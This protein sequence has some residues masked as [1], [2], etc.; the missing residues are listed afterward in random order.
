MCKH[1]W[2]G[3]YN[4]EPQA[5]LTRKLVQPWKTFLPSLLSSPSLLFSSPFPS[6]FLIYFLFLLPPQ[7]PLLPSFPSEP[8]G[9][10]WGERGICTWSTRGGSDGMVRLH[11][12]VGEGV[13]HPSLELFNFVNC[14]TSVL[15]FLQRLPTFGS[16]SPDKRFTP[17]L[18]P[19]LGNNNWVKDLGDAGGRFWTQ[20]L[21][22]PFSSWGIWGNL[23]FLHL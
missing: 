17:R 2:A 9:A 14:W 11:P 21:T 1:P 8:T 3:F 18:F 23:R 15:A 13:S 20:I 5:G 19:S 7:P 10:E 22:W 4:K 16:Q 12:G 6:P